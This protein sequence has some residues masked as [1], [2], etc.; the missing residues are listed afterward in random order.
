M[1]ALIVGS[2]SFGLNI[3]NQVERSDMTDRKTWEQCLA[4]I[5]EHTMESLSDVLSRTDLLLPNNPPVL[6]IDPQYHG[7]SALL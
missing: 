1:A 6:F 3:S 2:L 4:D 5:H 7:I